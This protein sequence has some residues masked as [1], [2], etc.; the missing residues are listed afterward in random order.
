MALL[1]ALLALLALPH[2][3]GA[4]PIDPV[5]YPSGDTLIFQSGYVRAVLDLRRGSLDVLQGSLAGAG[6]FSGAPNLAG[7]P[8]LV[9]EGARRG[10]L[11]VTLAPGGGAPVTSTA[12]AT[13]A[14]PLAYTVLANSSAE[15]A[16]AAIVLQDAQGRVEVTL[17][18]ALPPPPHRGLRVAV[19]ARALAA[20]SPALVAVDVGVGAP[21]ALGWYARGV[22]Q[23]LAMSHGY[24]SSASPLQRAYALGDGSQGCLELVL[25][26]GAQA[27]PSSYLFAGASPRPGLV[28]GGVGLTLW[29]LPA[30]LDAWAAGYGGGAPGAPV[31]AGATAD[32][33]FELYP[34]DYAFPPSAVPALLPPR[35]NLT[36]LASTLIAAHGSSVAALHS[37]DY[38]PEVRAAP[39][40]AH[41]DGQ[42]YAPN[43]NFYDPDSAISNS[44][45]LYTFDPALAQQVRGQ[46]ETNM[47]YVCNASS[48]MCQAGQCI[49]HFVG[50]CAGL[51]AECF[52]TTT[53]A[54]VQDCAV[55]DALSGAVQTGPNVFTILAALRYAG[56]TGDAAWLAAQ[57]PKLRAMMGFL[58]ARFDEAVGLYNAPGS[59]QI[60]V[61]I[62]QNFTSDSN[63]MGVLLCELFADGESA[64]GNAS[65]AAFYTA[66]AARLRQGMNAHLWAAS[67]DHYCTQSD[68]APGGGV[69]Q[70]SR[71]FIDY[72][73]NALAVA[74][75]VPPTAAAAAAVLA[76]MDAG[77]CTHAGRAT[78]VSEVRYN[79]SECVNGNDGDSSVAMGRI[80]WQD[81][82][83]RLAVGTPE[84]SAVFEGALLAPLQA[85]LL[86]RTW[87]PEC[88]G[89]GWDGSSAAGAAGALLVLAPGFPARLTAPP[90]LSLSPSP[91]AQAL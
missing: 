77:A 53:P 59:L 54:G 9:P 1:V 84:A 55:Y 20:F 52:C 13:R 63:A 22:R 5:V 80:G 24:I 37:Y 82:L 62:R 91:A 4:A 47:R 72:D 61:F 87:L 75:R 88:V 43:Y 48:A 89:W 85:D 31:A 44:A 69:V 56:T 73:A 60:D 28:S 76:R 18:L 46:L 30:P 8:A 3:A 21:S 32:V 33:S 64:L 68:P 11:A 10:A 83:A 41:N 7:L 49:H 14:S 29:G 50:S 71:D 27:P 34:N 12:D 6:D 81:A 67:G 38:F 35:T 74:A 23:G 42:C 58:D 39:C 86:R 90:P 26:A 36:D 57:A 65:G 25:P 78:W 70:C 2:R 45:M 16:S 79:K 15:G 19:A 17:T 51:G 66:R 40:L